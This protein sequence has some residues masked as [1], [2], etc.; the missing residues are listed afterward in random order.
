MRHLF[1]REIID[2]TVRRKLIGVADIDVE[3]STGRVVVTVRGKW[4]T[5]LLL[6]LWRRHAAEKLDELFRVHGTFS[7]RYTVR[8]T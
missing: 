5:K 2:S 4:W 6:G 7:I 3:E 1:T 8:I